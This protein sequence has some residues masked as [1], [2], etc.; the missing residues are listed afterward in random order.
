MIPSNAHS[1]KGESSRTKTRMGIEA[2]SGTFEFSVRD[3]SDATAKRGFRVQVPRRILCYTLLVFFI[4][5]IFLFLY[6]EMIKQSRKRQAARFHSSDPNKVLPH[7]FNEELLQPDD[8]GSIIA[9]LIGAEANETQ[10]NI[11]QTAVEVTVTPNDERDNGVDDSTKA[12]EVVDEHA[13]DQ[14]T[15]GELPV[16]DQLNDPTINSGDGG[17]PAEELIALESTLEKNDT[18]VLLNDTKSSGIDNEFGPKRNRYLR[19]SF[20][21]A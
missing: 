1:K 9:T 18:E 10:V 2:P 19:A 13:G 14:V 3:H 5:P 12:I 21:Y 7:T 16:E 6:V 17:I 11:A 20:A 4:L 8:T 15:P